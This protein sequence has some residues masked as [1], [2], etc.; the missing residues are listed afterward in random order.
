[1]PNE[2]AT[3]AALFRRALRPH[4]DPADVERCEV[5]NLVSR[6]LERAARREMRHLLRTA[7]ARLVAN[8]VERGWTNGG[9]G[10]CAECGAER[11]RHPVWS[12][13]R[14]HYVTCPR[15]HRLHVEC[16]P[17]RAV[18]SALAFDADCPRCLTG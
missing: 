8:L 18:D 4:P 17:L 13:R 15:G 12:K 7:F 10:V 5:E 6:A 3:V 14:P 1:M 2:A 9:E 16:L 11:P